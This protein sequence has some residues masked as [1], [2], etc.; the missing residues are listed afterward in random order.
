[1]Q[2]FYY[3]NFDIIKLACLEGD[4]YGN[5]YKLVSRSHEED[6]GRNPK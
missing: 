3:K 2:L 1:M 4:K 6:Q 5:E